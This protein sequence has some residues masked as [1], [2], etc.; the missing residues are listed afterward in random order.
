M[1]GRP[2]VEVSLGRDLQIR[3]TRSPG[4]VE[5]LLEP[6]SGLRGAAMAQLPGFV[7]ALRERGVAVASAEVRASEHTAPG[8]VTLTPRRGSATN[9]A[10]SNPGGT[11]AKW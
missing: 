3:I 6:G 7:A 11:V 10:G 1:A 2:F 9:A 4:G 5:L 8:L